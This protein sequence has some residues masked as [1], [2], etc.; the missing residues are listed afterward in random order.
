[1]SFK[2]SP[3]FETPTDAGGDNTYNLEVTA[4]ESGNAHTATRSVAITVTDVGDV[5]PAF[6][7]GNSASFAENGTGAVYTA[8]ATPDVTGASIS[9]S[10]S[11]GADSAQFSINS[12]GV[13]S[14]ISSP[15]FE[16]PTAA[17]SSNVYDL[18]ITATEAGNAVTATRSVA[19]TVTDVD[20]TAPVVKMGSTVQLE[21]N[22]T[23]SNKD[24][25]PQITAVGT[26]GDYVVVWKGQNSGTA[27]DNSI[28]VQQFVASGAKFGTALQLDG[29]SSVS[30]PDTA[31][32]VTSVGT[33][34]ES[35]VV[36][37]GNS[38]RI[39]VQKL[40]ASGAKIG[41]A[42]QLDTTDRSPGFD[43]LPQ[44]SSVGTGGEFVVVWKGFSS[45]FKLYVQ[46][47]EATGTPSGSAVALGTGVDNDPLQ[48]TAVGTGGEYVV[49]WRAGS[50]STANIFVQKFHANGSTSGNAVQLQ[51][52]GVS[53]GEDIS[54]PNHSSGHGGRIRGD[55]VWG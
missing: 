19:V 43:T 21:A 46:K 48:I 30:L 6:T 54:P 53:N 13:V 17:G 37:Q 24:E 25:T 47:F 23:T 39:L 1:M 7:S 42:V 38:N 34:G 49:A 35:V 51:A 52:T 15:D 29:S 10:I 44:V 41:P 8:V 36:W 22:G 9:Y 45:A 40:D 26:T 28:F 31:P 16:N 3:D 50:A 12:S 5:A 18:V 2:N 11:G 14:F 27:T 33:S 55:L 32:Q 20:D 4:T